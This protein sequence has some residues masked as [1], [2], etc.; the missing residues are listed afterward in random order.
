MPLSDREREQVARWA[1]DPAGIR[2]FDKGRLVAWRE[3]ADGDDREAIDGLLRPAG[4]DT[5]APN[6]AM[7]RG[8]ARARAERPPRNPYA[9]LG[10]T[11]DPR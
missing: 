3:H 4:A 6:P 1:E 7:A 11:E 2:G 10:I 9:K 8:R 5:P